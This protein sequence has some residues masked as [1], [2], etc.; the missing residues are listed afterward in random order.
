MSIFYKRKLVATKLCNRKEEAGRDC[1]KRLYGQWRKIVTSM[2]VTGYTRHQHGL[3]GCKN[4]NC[5][6]NV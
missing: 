2:H 1:A 6:I 5:Y 3:L 4:R